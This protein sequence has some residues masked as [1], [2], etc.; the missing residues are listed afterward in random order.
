MEPPFWCKIGLHKSKTLKVVSEGIPLNFEDW[1][2]LYFKLCKC[3]RC[4]DEWR[5]EIDRYT[6][7][8]FK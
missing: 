2:T 6:Y 1:G 8:C 7:M 4:G 5:Q 3:Q